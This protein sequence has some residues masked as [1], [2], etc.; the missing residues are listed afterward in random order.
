[1]KFSNCHIVFGL[2]ALVVAVAG[3]HAEDLGVVGPTYPTAEHD[4]IAMLKHRLLEMQANGGLAAIEARARQRALRDIKDLPAVP[5]L[6][7]VTEYASRL[8]DPTVTY[9][10][11]ITNDEGAVIVPAGTRINPL[12]VVTLH[13]R[14]VFFDGRD[15]AQ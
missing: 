10:K 7:T 8:I 9:A 12:D 2:V 1:M 6:T 14:L 13:E 5:G 15:P 4:A 3:A 11:P